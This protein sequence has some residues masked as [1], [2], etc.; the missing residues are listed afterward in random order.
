MPDHL[1]FPPD[2]EHVTLRDRFYIHPMEFMTAIGSTLFGLCVVLSLIIPEFSP[3]RSMDRMPWYVVIGVGVLLGAGGA[4]AMVGLHWKNT[5]EVVKGWALERLGW[6]LTILGYFTYAATVS[7]HYPASMFA[8]GVPLFI[9]AS[10]GLRVRT[11]AL[12]KREARKRDTGA[13]DTTDA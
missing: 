5:A 7:W 13:G 1:R 10:A 11:L 8:W 12:I 9:A 2:P 4:A 3:S 6:M